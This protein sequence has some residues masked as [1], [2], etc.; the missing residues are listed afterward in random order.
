MLLQRAF[1]LS[2][3]YGNLRINAAT[4][5]SDE[6]SKLS[7]RSNNSNNGERGQGVINIY[8]PGMF[9]GNH[10]ITLWGGRFT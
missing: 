3:Y 8:L 6:V 1:D 10:Y 5:G 4:D 2:I 9:G 7:H